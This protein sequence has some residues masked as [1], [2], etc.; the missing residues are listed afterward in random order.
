MPSYPPFTRLNKKL[1]DY[2]DTHKCSHG[3]LYTR[4]HYS[5]YLKENKITERIGVLD[6]E[7]CDLTANF[8]Y[9]I[10][11][12]IKRLDGEIIKRVLSSKEILTY[13]FD[14]NLLRDLARDIGK[15]D[16]LIT[17]YGQGFDI[18]DIRTRAKQIGIDVLTYNSMF[19]H[20]LYFVARSKF[21]LVS[22]KLG[23]AC[24]FFGIPAKETPITPEMKWR[25][26]AGNQDA[27]NLY[28]KHNVEDVVSTE[29]IYRICEPFFP[30]TNK[31]V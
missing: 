13:Q 14:K 16:K 18:P 6:I 29:K 5:C 22:N 23:N 1:V 11:Y 4:G 28:L 3:W 25:A 24:K 21:N 12:C 9:L 2:L 7:T 17:W 15:F 19:Q 30:D 26:M 20:D 10:S 27:L 31:S 8:G